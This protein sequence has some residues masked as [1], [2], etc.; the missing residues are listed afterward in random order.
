MAQCLCPKCNVE[1]EFDKSCNRCRGILTGLNILKLASP[2][3]FLEK[4]FSHVKAHGELSSR[5]CPVCANKMTGVKLPD[6]V[7]VTELDF[8]LN[9]QSLWFDAEEIKRL[10]KKTIEEKTQI[11]EEQL[12]TDRTNL[13]KY[14]EERALAK[15]RQQAVAV[16]VALMTI[17]QHSQS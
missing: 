16:N 10:P 3:G 12:K 17:I 14:Y 1:L 7:P 15:S 5:E 11:I 2:E 6:V 9:C 8:C 4:V 13:D